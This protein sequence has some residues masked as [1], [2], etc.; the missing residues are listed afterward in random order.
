MSMSREIIFTPNAAT[1]PATYGQ[2]VKAD[3]LVFASGTTP[4]DPTSGAIEGLT[5]QE[6][7]RQCLK[8]VSAILA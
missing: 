3:G 6:Q 8:N 7:T 2:A 4:V 5:T 1:P